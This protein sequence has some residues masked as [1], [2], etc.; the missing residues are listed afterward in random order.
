MIEIHHRQLR[1]SRWVRPA[2][3]P[4]WLRAGWERVHDDTP[5]PVADSADETPGPDSDD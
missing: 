5:A 4:A 1:L 2:A 3:L